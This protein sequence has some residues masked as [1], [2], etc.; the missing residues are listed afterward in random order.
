MI[1]PRQI[2]DRALRLWN[3]PKVKAAL[4]G[5]STLFPHEFSSA[6]PASDALKRNYVGVKGWIAELRAASK[7]VLGRG[8]SLRYDE[9]NHRGL[10]RQSVPARIVV[11]TLE[12]CLFLADRE[13][14]GRRFESLAAKALGAEPGLRPFL[15][16]R[17]SFVLEHADDLD[18]LLAVCDYFMK[19]PKTDLFLRQLSIP[20]V[21]TKFIEARRGLLAE[22]LECLAPAPEGGLEGAGPKKRALE[23]RFGLRYEPPSVRFRLLDP[24]MALAGLRD[25]TVPLPEFQRL[26]LTLERVFVVENKVSGLCFPDAPKS[27]VIF[28]MG[29]G[30]ESLGGVEW[31]RPLDMRY[32]GDIDTHGFA[33]LS[34]LRSHFP[35]LK[36]LMMDQDTLLKF[37]DLRSVEADSERFLGDLKHLSTQEAAVFEGLKA[38]RWGRSVRL[39]QERVSDAHIR[40]QLGALIG[41]DFVSGD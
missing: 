15:M 1:S 20:G 24:G 19:H 23:R 5:G 16:R 3:G 14:E 11:E 21:D 27:A 36:S 34:A 9:S 13:D 32:W 25:L 38:D 26:D 2:R 35:D 29:Y 7:E 30:V 18:G 6:P 10:G 33:I 41:P 22:M 8:Y 37:K 39:E 17:P 4:L 12:D 40:G 31:L 28:G